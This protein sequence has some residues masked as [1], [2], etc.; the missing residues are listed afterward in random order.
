MA[1]CYEVLMISRHEINEVRVYCAWA[2]PGMLLSRSLCEA[3]ACWG[4]WAIEFCWK[5]MLLCKHVPLKCMNLLA[6]VVGVCWLCSSSCPSVKKSSMQTSMRKMECWSGARSHT[7]VA[8]EGILYQSSW[9]SMKAVKFVTFM[10]QINNDLDVER[11][12]KHPEVLEVHKHSS[13]RAQGLYFHTWNKSC[14]ILSFCPCGFG[15]CFICGDFSSL[16]SMH[17]L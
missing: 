4:S 5:R 17:L 10:I 13:I 12:C 9:I 11:V 6:F 16:M 3:T 2:S 8:R 15:E 14:K 1:E 7:V